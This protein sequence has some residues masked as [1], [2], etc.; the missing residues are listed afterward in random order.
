M[1]P[2]PVNRP[3]HYCSHPSGIE[4]IVLTEKMNFN[5]GNAFKYL[6]RCT[7]KGNALQDLKK[8]Q[9][10]I[11]RELELRKKLRFRWLSED[12]YF[13]AVFCKDDNIKKVIY[14]DD[15]YSA[16]M[17]NALERLYTAS[18]QKRGIRALEHAAL[19]VASMII[20]EEGGEVYAHSF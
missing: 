11:N 2:D 5:V 13:N 18:V 6:Y 1:K 4:A 7:E 9:W 3:L 12:Q 19:A 8:A 14:Y 15:R 17:S 20:I 16:W 10:Y